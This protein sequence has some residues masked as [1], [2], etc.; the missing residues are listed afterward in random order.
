[1]I[2]KILFLKEAVSLRSLIY[3]IENIQ[4]SW[5]FASW[6]GT[7]RALKRSAALCLLARGL[8][9]PIASR[10]L[11]QFRSPLLWLTPTLRPPPVR[12][13]TP[14]SLSLRLRSVMCGLAQPPSGGRGG[15]LPAHC[16]RT[17]I[18]GG[19]PPNPHR[20]KKKNG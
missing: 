15:G 3:S 8:V 2:F 9:A 4:S 6:I 18:G 16:F 10:L 11:P 12:Q 5:G 1:M 13:P 14:P 7:Q 17:Q 20:R 19:L